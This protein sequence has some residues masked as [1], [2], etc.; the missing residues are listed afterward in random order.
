MPALGLL[1][2]QPLFDSYN[3]RV[4]SANEKLDQNDPQYRPLIDFDQHRDQIDKFKQ[5]F[6]YET[7]RKT[8]EG[9]GV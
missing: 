5:N 2:E 1:L 7:M 4:R 9:H 8:E 6:I 3:R